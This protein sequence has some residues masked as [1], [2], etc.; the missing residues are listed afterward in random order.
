MID[1]F[2]RN[3]DLNFH[4]AFGGRDQFFA[5]DIVGQEVSV[6]D[7]QCFF[8]RSDDEQIHQIEILVVS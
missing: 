5:H 7:A 6:L 2:S 8:G 3:N 4:S 1:V